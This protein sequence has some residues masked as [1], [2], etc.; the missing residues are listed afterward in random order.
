MSDVELKVKIEPWWDGGNLHVKQTEPWF[1]HRV[2]HVADSIAEAAIRDRLFEFIWEWTFWHNVAVA[3]AMQ[4][5]ANV[6]AFEATM[7]SRDGR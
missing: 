4:K 2:W 5:A 1:E 6:G 3:G 7:W